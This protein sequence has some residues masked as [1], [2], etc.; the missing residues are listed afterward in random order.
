MA[1]KRLQK[2]HQNGGITV[3]Y[4]YNKNKILTDYFRHMDGG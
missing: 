2:I 1:I 4:T 3:S